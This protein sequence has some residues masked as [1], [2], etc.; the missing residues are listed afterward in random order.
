MNYEEAAKFV[1]IKPKPPTAVDHA[2][3]AA[4]YLSGGYAGFSCRDML[5]IEKLKKKK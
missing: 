1:G 3:D 2:M 4:R 5:K